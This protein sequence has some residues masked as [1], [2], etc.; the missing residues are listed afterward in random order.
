MPGWKA[1]QLDAVPAGL[2]YALRDA[3]MFQVTVSIVD[4]ELYYGRC[5]T[6]PLAE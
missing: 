2:T 5:F 4:H 1:A 3:C 6:Q